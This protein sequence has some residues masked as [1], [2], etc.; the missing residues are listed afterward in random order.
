MTRPL[1]VLS[2]YE[3]FFTGG[4]RI[5]HTDVIVGLHAA[6]G[7]QHSVLTIAREASR[8]STVQPMQHDPS[9]RRLVR[10][11]VDVATLG[12]TAT[13]VPPER[14]TFSAEELRKA[15]HAVRRADLILSL[16]EQPLGLLLAL[17]DRGMMP[18]IPVAAC[19]HRSDPMHSGP[20]LGWL[21]EAAT[22]GLLTST[23]S[24]ADSTS[25]AY[26]PVLSPSVSRHVIPNGIDLDRFRPGTDDEVRATRGR[27]GIPPGAPVVVFAAR[28]DAMK[29]PGLFLRAVAAHSRHRP[30]VH[31]VLCGAGMTEEN[32]AL[33][34]VMSES[35]VPASARVHAL[36]IRHDM[37]AIYQIADIVAL[38]SAF[39]EASPLCLLEGA[40]CGAT[41]VTTSVGDSARE[42]EGI[43][44]VTSDDP[45]QIASCWDAVLEHRGELRAV[46]LAARPRLG[47]DRMIDEYR[48]VVGSL[49]QGELAAA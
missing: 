12:R 25:D 13:S 31:Y 20:A 30:D 28:F 8:E 19:L 34:A 40:A 16:K 10:S 17:R 11:G 38:T 39:G 48:V 43:G 24:C 7:Q 42:V 32:D 14:T 21:A 26:A 29:N 27:L 41:P 9:Y 22:N 1:R 35:G 44:L 45:V 36:G 5:L 4:A 18:D 46:A 37:P 23:I 49:L 33:R 6:G 2:L 3:G 15:S 47:R